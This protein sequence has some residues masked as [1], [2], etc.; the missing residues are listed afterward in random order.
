M[1]SSR[2]NFLYVQDEQEKSIDWVPYYLVNALHLSP[3]PEEK[4]MYGIVQTP[5][6]CIADRNCQHP[7]FQVIWKHILQ[8]ELPLEFLL[9]DKKINS[10]MIDINLTLLGEIDP[11]DVS[12]SFYHHD[13]RSFA[14]SGVKM[15]ESTELYSFGFKRST[16]NPHLCRF[17]FSGNFKEDFGQHQER[18]QLKIKAKGMEE[19][20]VLIPLQRGFSS[21]IDVTMQ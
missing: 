18:V 12:F 11:K 7:T 3:L 15:A 5:K 20:S 2:F 13:G 1:P 9:V 10:F 16:T 21:F 6:K 8:R 14:H 4:S 19:Q 17:Y